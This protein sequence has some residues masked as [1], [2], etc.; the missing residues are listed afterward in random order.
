[1]KEWK[2]TDSVYPEELGEFYDGDMVLTPDQVE[3]NEMLDEKY[4]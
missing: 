4:R 2:P 1:M 3:K